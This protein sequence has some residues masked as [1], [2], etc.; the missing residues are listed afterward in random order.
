M[1]LT[2]NLLRNRRQAGIEILGCGFVTV[3][4]EAW[5]RGRALGELGAVLGRLGG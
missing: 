3:T 1:W 5:G 4:G 2:G